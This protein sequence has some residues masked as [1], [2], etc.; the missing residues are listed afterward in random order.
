MKMDGVFLPRVLA[1]VSFPV[2][3]PFVC[4]SSYHLMFAFPI[5]IFSDVLLHGGLA[6]NK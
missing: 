1:A 3:K 5:N 4:L 6:P 2:V